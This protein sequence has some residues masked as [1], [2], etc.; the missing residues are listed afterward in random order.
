MAKGLADIQGE[1]MLTE[2]SLRQQIAVRA[3]ELY[4]SRGC[5]GGGD[6]EDWVQAEEE[7][8]ASFLPQELARSETEIP[9]AKTA[10]AAKRG[11]S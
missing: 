1:N 7:I 4:L 5:T 2:D 9:A 10:K 11:A 6:V 8:I 3:Y